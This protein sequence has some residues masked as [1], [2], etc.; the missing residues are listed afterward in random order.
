M[1]LEIK[2]KDLLKFLIKIRIKN[3]KFHTIIALFERF[4]ERAESH[5]IFLIA[6]GISFNIVLYI[7]PMM[8]VAIYLINL[9]FGVEPV[10]SFIT[11]TIG[12]VLPPSQ[13]SADFLQTLIDELNFI[14]G[15][16]SILGWIGIGTLLWLSSTLLSSFRTGLNAI[17]HI[18]TPNIFLLY[19]IKDIFLIIVLTFLI[20]IASFIFP[21]ISITATLLQNSLP[22]SMRFVF[23]RLYMTSFSLLIS[24]ILFYL[25][26]RFVPNRKMDR[27]IR[28]VS[29]GL[30]L[31]FVEISR[32]IF[33][34]Y[35]SGVTSYG[36]FYGTY[37]ILASIAVWLYYLTLIILFSAESAQFLNDLRLKKLE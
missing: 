22:D 5:H 23:S 13:V 35:L 28:F 32:Y 8:L 30:C 9:I 21:L 17:F 36:K 12:K 1:Q 19:K 7:I 3:K 31:F 6:A 10:T 34:W 24:F 4:I 14:L 27:F 15:K 20:L 33:A 26:F 16:S 11:E 2:D 37:A 18:P 29:I 25:L